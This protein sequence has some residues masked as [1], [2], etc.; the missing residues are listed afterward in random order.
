MASTATMGEVVPAGSVTGL[1]AAS[2]ILIAT[3]LVPRCLAD[4][5]GLPAV[6]PAAVGTDD[7]GQLALVAVRAH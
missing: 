5:H 4:L 7:V 6:I 1:D 3:C 2:V